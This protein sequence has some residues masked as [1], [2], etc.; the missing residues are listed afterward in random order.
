L[1]YGL[2]PPYYFDHAILIGDKK[3]VSIMLESDIGTATPYAI[4]QTIEHHD[5]TILQLLISDRAGRYFPLICTSV[6]LHSAS[7]EHDKFKL[8]Y[9]AC[10]SKYP[11]FDLLLNN[12]VHQVFSN[13]VTTRNIDMVTFLLNITSPSTTS[14][15]TFSITSDL[16]KYSIEFQ[17]VEMVKLLVLHP[18]SDS[19]FQ[20]YHALDILTYAVYS[21]SV[22]IV[23]LL[24]ND[25]RIGKNI[26]TTAFFRAAD[27]HAVGILGLFEDFI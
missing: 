23:K 3:M 24:L 20:D 2:P 8:I 11:D 12:I 9:E 17:D 7:L 15:V 5:I 27:I 6:N 1:A 22:E 13:S 25:P 21:Q 14:P 4:A 16:I 18:H 26:K 19:V 10:K